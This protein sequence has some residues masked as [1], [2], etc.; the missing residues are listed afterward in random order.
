MKNQNF[1]ISREMLKILKMLK[2]L[3]ELF[4]FLGTPNF[5]QKL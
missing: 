2:F 1:N 5:P 4:R 3:G